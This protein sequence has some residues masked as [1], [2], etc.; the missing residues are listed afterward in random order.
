MKHVFIKVGWKGGGGGRGSGNGERWNYFIF[1][2][3]I[4]GNFLHHKMDLRSTLSD[5]SYV[6]KQRDCL[7]WLNCGGGGGGQ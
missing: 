7:S 4:I 2:N 6:I 3:Q 5:Y 1:K